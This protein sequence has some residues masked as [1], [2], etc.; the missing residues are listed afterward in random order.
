LS[1]WIVSSDKVRALKVVLGNDL[2]ES[3]K[4]KMATDIRQ[5]LFR[6]LIADIFIVWKCLTNLERILVSGIYTKMSEKIN[7]WSL[8]SLVL[9]FSEDGTTAV[10]TCSGLI[11]LY[12]VL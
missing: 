7:V 12:I 6:Y 5:Q 8:Y 1:Y 2:N 11:V 10:E 9:N 3:G 4:C